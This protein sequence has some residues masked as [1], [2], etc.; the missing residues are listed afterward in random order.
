MEKKNLSNS[1]ESKNKAQAHLFNL[2]S[3]IIYLVIGFPLVCLLLLFAFAFWESYKPIGIIVICG[4]LGGLIGH[5]FR[6]D[7]KDLI[8]LL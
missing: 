7:F 6:N 8:I 1:E 5:Y 3:S 4:I 2:L